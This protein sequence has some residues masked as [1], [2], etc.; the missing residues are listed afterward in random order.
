MVKIKYFCYYKAEWVEVIANK[1]SWKQLRDIKQGAHP[2]D[3]MIFADGM[4][5][6]SHRG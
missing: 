3:V 1:E 6:T 5:E 4:P 2:N